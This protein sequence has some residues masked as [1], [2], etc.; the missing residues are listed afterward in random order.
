MHRYQD[1]TR[2][3]IASTHSFALDTL[4]LVCFAKRIGMGRVIWTRLKYILC[5]SVESF[6]SGQI[7][8]VLVSARARVG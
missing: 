1:F 6:V 5:I 2:T 3:R 8:L 7:V 4:P